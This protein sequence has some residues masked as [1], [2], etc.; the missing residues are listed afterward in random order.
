VMVVVASLDA[1]T[2][3]EQWRRLLGPGGYGTQVAV[4][5]GGDV[6]VGAFTHDPRLGASDPS[7][8][9]T[10]AKLRGG[11]GGGFI[12]TACGAAIC[13][14]CET[15]VAPD[16]CASAPAAGCRA[17]GKSTLKMSSSATADR[18]R[19]VWRWQDPAGFSLATLGDPTRRHDYAVCMFQDA[20]GSPSLVLRATA[21]AAAFCGSKPCWKSAGSGFAWKDGDG[22]LEGLVGLKLASGSTGKG[23]TKGRGAGLALPPLPLIV[24][25]VA[26]VRSSTGE[27]W[28]E[29]YGSVQL[30]GPGTL[31][32]KNQ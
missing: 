25:I 29:S 6:V 26:E 21:T 24:P 5:A 22:V 28:T 16:T 30:N 4:D 13:A 11:D 31:L 23:A 19:L 15:C 3:A 20:A 9:L 27:C 8:A 10:V 7:P 2:G 14:A 1:A 12:G 18:D 17:I 32:A